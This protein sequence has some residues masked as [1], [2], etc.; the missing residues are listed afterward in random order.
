[1][2]DDQ[3]PP[4][5]NDSYLDTV[6]VGGREPI[7]AV[8]IADYD[9]AWPERFAAE[10]ERIQLALAGR[11][12]RIEHIGST[13]VP[14]LAAKPIV[15]I[16]VTLPDVGVEESPWLDAALEAAGYRLRVRE[17]GHRMYRTPQRD[18]HVHVYRD[19]D[20]EAAAYLL[21]RDQLRSSPEERARYEATKRAL[22]QRT[23]TDMNYYADAKS[24]VV[25]DILR[26]AR[27]DASTDIR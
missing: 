5:V 22:A 14:G 25:A 24:E 6:L 11:V 15:D 2:T 7:A 20:P 1:M 19:D 4:V 23:W 9:P 8:T 12:R 13:A 27:A 16:L 3:Q 17:P 21:F 18:V 10:R 26:R